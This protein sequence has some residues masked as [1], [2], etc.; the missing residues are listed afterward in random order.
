MLGVRAVKPGVTLGDVGHVIGS[1]VEG[2]RFSVVRDFCGH[3]IGR[4]FHETARNV[5]HSSAR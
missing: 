1:F 4:R 5:L 3:G 2:Q